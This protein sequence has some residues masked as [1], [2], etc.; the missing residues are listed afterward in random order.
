[1]AKVN[2]NLLPQ[3]FTAYQ[4]KKSKFLKVQAIG[5]AAILLVTFLSSLTIALRI[6]QTQSIKV[7]QLNVNAEE[8]RVG[9]LRDKQ[10][11]LLLLKNRLTII[12]QYL[13]LPSPQSSA[14]R[15]INDLLSPSLIISSESIDRS[16]EVS[17]LAVVPNSQILDDLIS[18]LTTKELNGGKIEKV[19]IDSLNRGRE[20]SYRISFKVKLNQ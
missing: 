2:I 6:L 9:N 10:A 12:D 8:D 20:G 16:G 14:F 5:I 4:A 3:E 17:I 19:S 1:M 18:S 15:R 11:S 7:A 13:G